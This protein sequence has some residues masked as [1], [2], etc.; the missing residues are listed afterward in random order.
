MLFCRNYSVKS[1]KA[2]RT[3][4]FCLTMVFLSL[5]AIVTFLPHIVSLLV[6]FRDYYAGIPF[7]GAE[8]SGFRNYID[9]LT[10]NNF[11][12]MLKNTLSVSSLCVLF[13]SG[14]TFVCTYGICGVKRRTP[15]FLLL[16]LCLLPALLPV[17]LFTYAFCQL[18]NLSLPFSL[19]RLFE[20]PKFFTALHETLVWGSLSILIGSLPSGYSRRKKALFAALVFISIRLVLFASYNL[21]FLSVI[22]NDLN[23]A[24]AEVFS[25]HAFLITRLNGNYGYGNAIQVVSSIFSVIPAV[26]GFVLLSKLYLNCRRSISAPTDSRR[27]HPISKLPV[28]LPVLVL[29]LCVGAILLV[30][31]PIYKLD[32]FDS[33]L[34]P[35]QLHAASLIIGILYPA[36]FSAIF[37]LL[38]FMIAYCLSIGKTSVLIMCAVLLFFTSNIPGKFLLFHMTRLT[39]TP[40]SI[41]LSELPLCLLFAL[42]LFFSHGKIDSM[43]S[44]MQFFRRSLPCMLLLFPICYTRIFEDYLSFSIYYTATTPYALSAYLRSNQLYGHTSVTFLLVCL[45]PCFIGLI[46]FVFAGMLRKTNMV[47]NESSIY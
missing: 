26:L 22:E 41:F 28:L 9:F 25:I 17:E 11:F 47:Q 45:I 27:I 46:C 14:Y 35:K 3:V 4:L 31:F 39:N 38:A 8:C 43:K 24:S 40:I 6:S 23:K 30:L 12:L 13:G 36:V 7:L 37:L 32:A 44:P 29:A 15:R 5:L 2:T 33:M 1:R 10:D 42:V 16:C 20:F 21:P 19:K 18:A 34:S